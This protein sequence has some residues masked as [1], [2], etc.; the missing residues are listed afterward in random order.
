MSVTKSIDDSVENPSH[1]TSAL[2]HSGIESQ[3]EQIF[4]SLS[5]YSSGH[6]NVFKFDLCFSPC[7]K[8]TI[9]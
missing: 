4:A 8:S 3:V 2:R 1:L 5:R 7:K 9:V 6:N